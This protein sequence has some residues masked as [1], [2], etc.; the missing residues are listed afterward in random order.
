MSTAQDEALTRSSQN[1]TQ[2]QGKLSAVDL[3]SPISQMAPLTNCPLSRAPNFPPGA[4]SPTTVED[5]SSAKIQTVFGTQENFENQQAAGAKSVAGTQL[6]ST[7]PTV[8]CAAATQQID[9]ALPASV[10]PTNETT[11]IT[12]PSPSATAPA[13]TTSAKQRQE[14]FEV[15]IDYPAL[16]KC[17][18]VDINI[19]I[20][21]W[22]HPTAVASGK[23]DLQ[24]GLN[25]KT[26]PTLSG[27]GTQ[28][29]LAPH[30]N[31]SIQYPAQGR[32]KQQAELQG[33][34]VVL[35]QQQ[36]QQ[37]QQLSPTTCEGNAFQTDYVIR[38][39]VHIPRAVVVRKPCVHER[40]LVPIGSC[41]F[42]V[43]TLNV[44]FLSVLLYRSW[45]GGWMLLPRGWSDA[46]GTGR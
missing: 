15:Y 34:V 11:T 1:H 25:G 32:P 30:P 9:R 33:Q 21:Q 26:V 22:S 29:L 43:L 4:S 41:I 31:V 39:K 12:K 14:P 10:T 37:S 35:Q 45:D 18:S 20:R 13:S 8:T 27:A 7:T 16:Q 46:K 17:E 19:D 23:G 38:H 2:P 36:Q 44:I 42:L 40:P 5:Q 28:K 24:T 6:N 3:T